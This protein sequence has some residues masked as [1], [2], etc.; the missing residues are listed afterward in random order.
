MKSKAVRLKEPG[1]LVLTE[2][3]LQPGLGEVVVKTF[4]TS[5]CDA[6]LRAYKGLY[7]PEDLPSFEWIGH[8][9]GGEVVEV[10]EGV[11]EFKP[12]DFVMCFGPNNA[13]SEYFK[14]HVNTLLP[15]IDGMSKEY[16]CLG[17][18]LAVGMFGVFQSGIQLGDEAA[19][20]GLNFQGLL[21]VEGLKKRGAKRVICIDYSKKHMDIARELGADV[22]LNT[23]QVDVV[24]AIRELTSDRGVDVALHSCGYWNPNAEAYFNKCIQVVRDEGI[25]ISLPDMMSAINVS[26][27]R[28]HHHAMEIR[29]PA[30][31]HHNP[32]F[33]RQWVPRVLRPVRDGFIDPSKLITAEFP[34]HEVEKAILVFEEDLEQVKIV[35]KP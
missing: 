19:V 21:A 17:E 9:G 16:C 2:K 15:A 31:M 32:E 28:I 12:G 18:P 5:I 20:F 4:Q 10:G 30:I 1:Q 26:L 8:E 11:R 22:V 7:M 23:D 33:L 3:D 13:W 6:D 14:A 27:H 24:Q 29:F 25:M 34:L 35:L